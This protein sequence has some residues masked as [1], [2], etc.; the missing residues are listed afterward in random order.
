MPSS[1]AYPIPQAGRLEPGL[2][3]GCSS[4]K[5]VQRWLLEGGVARAWV[6]S[7]A[8]GSSPPCT[9][10]K[11]MR[12]AGEHPP[13]SVEETGS[14]VSQDQAIISLE[15]WSQSFTSSALLAALC[16]TQ[17]L[18]GTTL[19]TPAPSARPLTLPSSPT[20]H[21]CPLRPRGALSGADP[22]TTPTLPPGPPRLS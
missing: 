14:H 5:W 7:L 6:M 16:P 21:S 8:G 4:G 22:L 18:P 2:L 19:H 9:I 12:G 17:P 1:P 11:F 13:L 20:S 3:I 10:V 15:L